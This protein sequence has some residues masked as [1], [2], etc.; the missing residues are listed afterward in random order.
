MKGRRDGRVGSSSRMKVPGGAVVESNDRRLKQEF[1][2]EPVKG[3]I[4][5]PIEEYFD[6][7]EKKKVNAIFPKHGYQVVWPVRS[8]AK[9]GIPPSSHITFN[10]TCAGAIL[11]RYR[12]H[13]RQI[14][15]HPDQ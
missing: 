2:G 13:I 15:R 10:L 8:I 4:G 9:A 11:S 3:R 5:M 14:D 7:T 6:R 12:R 1:F